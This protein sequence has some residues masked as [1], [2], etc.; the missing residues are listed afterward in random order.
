MADSLTKADI[1]M[2]LVEAR[3]LG[4]KEALEIVHDV[5]ELMSDVLVSGSD[6]KLSGFGTFSLRE[7]KARLGRNPKTGEQAEI[8]ARTVVSFKASSKLK[9]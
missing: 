6:L 2:Y 5:F 9:G 8:D 7:K 4:K 1:A 3:G